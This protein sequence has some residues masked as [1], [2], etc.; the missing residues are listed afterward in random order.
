[1]NAKNIKALSLIILLAFLLMSM[2]SMRPF[3]EPADTSMDDYFIE[4]SQKEISS[5]NVVTAVLF[6]YRGMDTLVEAS[7]LFAAATGVFLVF[8][9]SVNGK[10]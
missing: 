10:G 9:R 3:G 2:M 8:R 7:I 4:N 5:N 1:M 6:D